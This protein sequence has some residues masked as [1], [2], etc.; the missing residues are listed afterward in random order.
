[1]T[2]PNVPDLDDLLSGWAASVR[3]PD[4]TAEQVRQAILAEPRADLDPAWWRD[5]STQIGAVM[6]RA[7]RAGRAGWAAVPSDG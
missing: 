5:F 1:M 6:V 4:A 3:M 2:E 7:G